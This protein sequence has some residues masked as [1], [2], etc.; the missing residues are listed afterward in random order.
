MGVFDDILGTAGK[1]IGG[2]INADTIS[3]VLNTIGGKEGIAGIVSQFT[4]GGLG[5]VI[6]S[7]VGKGENKPVSA[8]QISNV[9]GND[10][11]GNIAKQLGLSTE[12]TSSQLSEILP[13]AIDK[14]TPEGKVPDGDILSKGMDL[15]KGIF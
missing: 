3:S 4:K 12:E 1:A 9:L 11:L 2:N 8:S 5:D 6:S 7:W 15:L 13:K 14:L 10:Q